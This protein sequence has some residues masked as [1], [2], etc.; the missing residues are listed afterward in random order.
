LEKVKLSLK[1]YYYTKRNKNLRFKL[2]YKIQNTRPKALNIGFDEDPLFDNK[3]LFAKK[4]K[5][6]N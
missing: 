6:K 5:L 3:D 4:P 2:K 1:K